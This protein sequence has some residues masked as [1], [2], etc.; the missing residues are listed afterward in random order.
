MVELFGSKEIEAACEVTQPAVSHAVRRQKIPSH[1][2]FKLA[3][4][5]ER[6]NIKIPLSLVHG[7]PQQ[8]GAE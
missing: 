7:A 4:L 6:H 8:E 3:P 1:W 2:Y 5:A